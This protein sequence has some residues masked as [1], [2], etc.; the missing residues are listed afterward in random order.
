MTSQKNEVE[1]QRRLLIVATCLMLLIVAGSVLFFMIIEEGQSKKPSPRRGTPTAGIS[2]TPVV[3]PTP[4]ILCFDYFLN[5]KNGWA[6][7]NSEGYTRTI[8]EGRLLLA[9]TNHK[10]LIESMPTRC[11][12]KEYSDFSLTTTFSFL[13]GDQHD[14]LGL[15]VR[16]DSNLDY[17]Y[18]I[19]FYGD[20]TYSISKEALGE[21][22]NEVQSTLV[23]RSLIPGSHTL[24]AE[25]TLTVMMKG[26]S[27]VL[28]L[29]GKMLTSITDTDYTHG[30]IALFV[31]HGGTSSG[32]AA[33]FHCVVIATPPAVLPAR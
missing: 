17:D 27:L 4:Q 9:S 21:D 3:Q 10:P 7:S 14:S 24:S 6:I 29:N 13:Q 19:A 22:N 33:A 26:P 18:R 15:Y 20:A 8:G 1:K 31:D 25:N 16:G 30:Q 28:L 12:S 32:V 2:P 23:S 5:N 11:A